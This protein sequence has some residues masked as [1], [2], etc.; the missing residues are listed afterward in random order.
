M[1]TA[2]F[3]RLVLTLM[4]LALAAGSGRAF[5]QDTKPAPPP[6]PFPDDPLALVAEGNKA[7]AQ[8]RYDDAA[9]Y[10]QKALKLD[11]RS[12]DAHLGL[13]MVHDFQG[14]YGEAEEELNKALSNAPEN[15][16]EQ[17]DSALT[18]LAVSYAFRGDVEGAER[19]YQKLYDFQVSTQRLDKAAGTAQTIGRAY[20]DRG[21]TKLAAQWYQTGQEAVHKMSGLAS[22]QLDLWQMRWEQAQSRI[23]ARSGNAEEAETHQAAMK[24]LVDKGGLNAAMGPSYYS[25][26]GHNAFDAGNYDDAI[27]ALQKADPRDPAI[28]TLLAEAYV[29]K[30]DAAA[31]QSVADKVAIVPAH[32]L[33]GALARQD[34]KKIQAE[35]ARLKAE[36]EKKAPPKEQDSKKQP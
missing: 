34:M 19:Y 25:L 28:L 1:A 22:D 7:K 11:S 8:G 4:M 21:D 9:T 24:A 35:V 5:A 36:Q 3:R 2:F 14:H 10:Y 33:Q 12:F 13:G 26:V 17:R 6:P 20:L 30:G 29:R 27:A 23:A 32:T 18:A 16:R 31:A 15:A